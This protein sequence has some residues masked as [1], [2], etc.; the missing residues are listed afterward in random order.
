MNAHL[1]IFGPTGSGKSASATNILSQIV[2]IYR[3]RLFIVEAG[4]SFG[5]LGDFAKKLGLTVNR[6]R[7]APGSGVSLAPFADAEKLIEPT[8][9][10]KTLKA[11]DLEASDEH[12]ASQTE[13]EQRDI[14]GEMEITARLMITGGEDKED[15]RLTRADRS[16]IRQ[17][18]LNAAQNV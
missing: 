5:L 10:V 18:I 7:L 4:N 8:A 6:V 12:L 2:A 17:C 14:L 9:N 3:P 15:A 13:D 11:D 16:A 1:F